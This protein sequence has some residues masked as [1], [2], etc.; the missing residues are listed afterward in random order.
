M[1]T[2]ISETAWCWALLNNDKVVSEWVSICNEVWASLP[3]IF[4]KPIFD[5]YF[6]E[7]SAALP[8]TNSRGIKRVLKTKIDDEKDLM[9]VMTTPSRA[10]ALL[11]MDLI[12]YAFRLSPKQ[13][14][15]EFFEEATDRN[16]FY[17]YITGEVMG[18]RTLEANVKIKRHYYGIT[19]NN[20]L[21]YISP[22]GFKK[23][24]QDKCTIESTTDFSKGSAGR[25]P[26]KCGISGS[27]GCVFWFWFKYGAKLNARAT[28]LF[29]IFIWVALC[30]DGGHSLQEVVGSFDLYAMYLRYRNPEMNKEAIGL[31]DQLSAYNVPVLQPIPESAIK[32]ILGSIV[33]GKKALKVKMLEQMLKAV[34]FAQTGRAMNIDDNVSI[35]LEPVADVINTIDT[36]LII[37]GAYV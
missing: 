20:V 37:G 16:N 19:N 34:K 5:D 4:S 21:N 11:W 22:V 14:P 27:A 18:K 9:S 15:E 12:L 1:T 30:L 23:A 7:P 6:R 25:Y 32:S 17:K 33:S 8:F 31:A 2:D 13:Y 24:G 29:L 10:I 35:L 28:K 3:E 36:E 26:I